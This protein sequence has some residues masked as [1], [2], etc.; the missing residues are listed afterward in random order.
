VDGPIS[1]AALRTG[2]ECQRMSQLYVE[3]CQNCR[4]IAW[5]GKTSE[6]PKCLLYDFKLSQL[7]S[8]DL[9][10]GLAGDS[11][12]ARP[13]Q[14]H[15]GHERKTVEIGHAMGTKKWIRSPAPAITK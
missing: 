11:S 8:L 1:L 13:H 12:T 5:I 7:L 15:S 2:D 3:N 14:E 9:T 10:D 4:F 6:C